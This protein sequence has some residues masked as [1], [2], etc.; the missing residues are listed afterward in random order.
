MPILFFH[1]LF[2]AVLFSALF[3]DVFILRSPA[4]VQ[5]ALQ[6]K[7]SGS[8]ELGAEAI[9]S[10]WRKI[11]GLLVMVVVLL[12]MALGLAQWMPR[13]SAY[14]PAIF[15]T[16]F[17]LVVILTILAKVRVFKERKSGIQ[18]GLTRAMFSIFLVVFILG[19][20]SK[21]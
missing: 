11:T 1:A 14:P 20:W 9:L 13:I 4:A 21:V 2:A 17:L 12:Q 19:I 15:H 5:L 8:S 18:V 7:A 6:V 3:A 16:K 10:K